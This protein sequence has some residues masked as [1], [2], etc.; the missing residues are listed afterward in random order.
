M[1]NFL[2]NFGRWW[3]KCWNNKSLVIT[4]IVFFVSTFLT[5]Y[6]FSIRDGNWIID[7][8]K[9]LT[10]FSISVSFCFYVF[11]VGR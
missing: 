3:G 10:I 2:S 8:F 9:F 11:N 5:A 6:L 1:L 4:P 7:W